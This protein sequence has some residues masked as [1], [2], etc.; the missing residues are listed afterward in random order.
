MSFSAFALDW[1]RPIT[2][3]WAFVA[4]RLEIP[5]AASRTHYVPVKEGWAGVRSDFV[6]EQLKPTPPTF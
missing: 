2:A 1:L 4:D 6:G 5:Y 3:S